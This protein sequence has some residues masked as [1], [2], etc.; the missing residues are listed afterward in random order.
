MT[1]STSQSPKQIRKQLG[2]A[3]WL[4]AL[5]VRFAPA[6]WTGGAPAYAAGGN[7]VSDAQLAERLEVS[8]GTISQWRRRLRS[9]ILIGWLVA[10]RQGESSTALRGR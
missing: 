9:A 1:P 10:P 5:F 8:Q 3:V 4:L 2:P 7:V 6:D